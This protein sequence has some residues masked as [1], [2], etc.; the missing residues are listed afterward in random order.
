[1]HIIPHNLLSDER[2]WAHSCYLTPTHMWRTGTAGWGAWRILWRIRERSRP[3]SPS[4]LWFAGSL[5]PYDVFIYLFCTKFLLYSKDVTFVSVPLLV[6][7]V[8][9]GPSTPGVYF[10]PGFWTPKP[11]CDNDIPLARLRA[12]TTDAYVRPPSVLLGLSAS[13]SKRSCIGSP[14]LDT[15]KHTSSCCSS[16]SWTRAPSLVALCSPARWSLNEQHPPK[17]QQPRD[18]LHIA[19]VSPICSTCEASSKSPQPSWSTATRRWICSPDTMSSNPGEYLLSRVPWFDKITDKLCNNCVCHLIA[20]PCHH[21]ASHAASRQKAQT[22][23][24]ACAAPKPNTRL[25]NVCVFLSLQL[26]WCYAHMCVICG[27]FKNMFG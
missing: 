8:R 3:S 14:P 7:C 18:P 23:M 20:A 24:H 9:L 21:R 22:D 19:C 17:W 11:G 15:K 13:T 4:Q 26:D 25:F 16:P 1:M 10:A 5:S 12:P 27:L 6:I 2:M